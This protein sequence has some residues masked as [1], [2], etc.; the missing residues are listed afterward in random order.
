[1][2]CQ[3]VCGVLHNL[4]FEKLRRRLVG[5][6][7]YSQ[8]N[9]VR[10]DTRA[11]TQTDRLRH[12]DRTDGRLGYTDKRR[13]ERGHTEGLIA[14][15]RLARGHKLEKRDILSSVRFYSWRTRHKLLQLTTLAS[16]KLEI[17]LELKVFEKMSPSTILFWAKM[18]CLPCIT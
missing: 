5:R 9:T 3:F 18:K 11:S 1:M 2:R 14:G 16:E 6:I 12:T 13:D 10:H 17:I 7:D 8:S 15:K 4:S